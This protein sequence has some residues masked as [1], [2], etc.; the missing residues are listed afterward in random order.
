MS[1]SQQAEQLELLAKASRVLAARFVPSLARKA[2]IAALAAGFANVPLPSEP[3]RLSDKEAERIRR[4][5]AQELATAFSAAAKESRQRELSADDFAELGR[6]VDP[7]WRTLAATEW[8]LVS[9][10]ETHARKAVATLMGE[11]TAHAAAAGVDRRSVLESLLADVEAGTGKAEE[12]S[13]FLAS[14]GAGNHHLMAALREA[15]EQ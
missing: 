2:A 14:H 10:L 4:D 11:V 3:L 7:L 9:K 5:V 1:H 8:E 6:A 13:Q 15:I 12:V